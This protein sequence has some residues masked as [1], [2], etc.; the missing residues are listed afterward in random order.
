MMPL[1]FS[2]RLKVDGIFA[3]LNL[4]R[5]KRFVLILCSNGILN[6]INPAINDA[7]YTYREYTNTKQKALTSNSCNFTFC[8][9]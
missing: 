6:Y 3:V 1:T 2:W 7:L 9:I 4:Q 8:A 5:P